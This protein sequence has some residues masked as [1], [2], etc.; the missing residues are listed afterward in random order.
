MDSS[1]IKKK[2]SVQVEYHHKLTEDLAILTAGIIVK[3]TTTP[4][5]LARY[6]AYNGIGF[7]SIPPELVKVYQ[8]TTRTEAEELP[9]D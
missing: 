2:T 3:R 5:K 9:L 8:I 7:T 6:S 4:D 1:S